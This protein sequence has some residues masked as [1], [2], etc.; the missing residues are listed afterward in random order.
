[1]YNKYKNSKHWEKTT[2]MKN[3]YMCH[4]NFVW[5]KSAFNLEP[6]RPVKNYLMTVANGCN[7]K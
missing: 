7:P 4:F 2:G 5:G 3:Q 1:M 6:K